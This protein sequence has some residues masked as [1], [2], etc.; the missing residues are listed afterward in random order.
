MTDIF[1]KDFY[2]QLSEEVLARAKTHGASSAEVSISIE[3]GFSVVSRLCQVDTVEHHQDKGLGLTVYFG[4]QTGSASSTDLS[5]PAIET[6]IDKACN[7][8][9]Y[10]NSDPYAG[11]ADSDLMA[12]GYPELDLDYPW[13]IE[14]EQ[15]LELAI[16][17]ER[18]AMQDSRITN[19]EGVSVNSHRSLTI[20]ANTHGFTGSYLGTQHNISCVL[21]AQAGGQMHRNYDYTV[22]RDA[23]DLTTIENLAQRAAD[24]TL[25]RLGARR[26]KTCT[27]PVIF[28]PE[29][30]KSLLGNFVNAISGNNIYRDSSFLIDRLN[31]QVFP[32]HLSLTQYPH[33]KKAMGSLPFDNEGVRTLQQDFVKDGILHSYLL[34]SYS[35]RKLGMQSTGN[36]GGICNLMITNEDL[37]SQE[38][39][40]KMARG[41]LVTELIG[42]G[43]NI[44]T[45]D[46]SRGAFGYW[47]ENGEIVY[48]VE[49]ITIAGN[50]KDMFLNI[51]AVA[52]DIDQRGRIQ[53]GS[54]LIDNMTIAG[55]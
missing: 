44:V 47:I 1:K 35:G 30:A 55:E 52:N 2:Q 51:V 39:I 34:N 29:M 4:Q 7:I 13:S 41:L 33:I 42:Q 37:S 50:L 8:A 45:G 19:S 20:F 12:F 38:L 18:L 26:L 46:Y 9:K 15:A 5:L 3:A 24:K 31:S 53:T 48:P 11:I 23:C 40:K 28:N 16:A 32:K 27:A 25:Q 49:E 6:A 43:V 54:I 22:A 10:T 21:I 17:C 14:P 36:A